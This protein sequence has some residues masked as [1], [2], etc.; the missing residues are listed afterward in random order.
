MAFERGGSS[1]ASARSA[2]SPASAMLPKRAGGGGKAEGAERHGRFG[3]GVVQ[4]VEGTELFL[5]AF[6]G[7]LSKEISQGCGIKG[8]I[9]TSA[10]Q[11]NPPPLYGG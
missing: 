5:V 10:T 11:G 7:R 6:K 3:A 1:P 4:F 8:F 2:S 9:P